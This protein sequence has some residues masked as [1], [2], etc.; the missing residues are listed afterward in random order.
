MQEK[1]N[2][3]LNGSTFTEAAFDERTGLTFTFQPPSSGGVTPPPVTVT[4]ANVQEGDIT[5]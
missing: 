4:I 5:F 1:L 2:E 3:T